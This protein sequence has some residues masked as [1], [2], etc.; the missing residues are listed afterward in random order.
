V[1]VHNATT[2]APLG[3][4]ETGGQGDPMAGVMLA[5]PPWL[6]F[7]GTYKGNFLMLDPA[8]LTCLDSVKVADGEAFATPVAIG[9][10]A[11]A[12]GGPD[13]RITLWE[14][15]AWK[16]ESLGEIHAD[17]DGIDEMVF[18]EGKLWFLARRTF[19]C[20]DL[21]TRKVRTFNIGDDMSCLTVNPND[22]TLALLADG[23][24]VCID[25]R[26]Q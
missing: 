11:V 2:G 26:K 10:T 14:T 13:G 18:F 20:V 25:M 9:E 22:G 1:Y 24:V 17:K 4:I 15:K 7:T 19:G 12:M 8:T 3:T 5:L 21:E 6:M 16:F 23:D